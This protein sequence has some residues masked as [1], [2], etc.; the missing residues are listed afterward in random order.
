MTISSRYH[1]DY[2]ECWRSL[3]RAREAMAKANLIYA[4][5]EALVEAANNPAAEAQ[6]YAD[7]IEAHED[8][9]YFHSIYRTNI[10]NLWARILKEEKVDNTLPL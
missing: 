7:H 4:S 5:F 3:L 2:Q 6:A 8:W 9:E 10:D 1:D